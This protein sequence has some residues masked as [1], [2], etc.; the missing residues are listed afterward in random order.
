[1]KRLIVGMGKS[2]QAVARRLDLEGATYDV[3]DDRL[4]LEAVRERLGHVR[5]G[6]FTTVDGIQPEIYGEV[7]VSPGVSIRHPVLARFAGGNAT[8]MGELEFAFR[9]CKGR[10]VAVTGS[11]GKSTTVT[12]IDHILSRCGFPSRLCGN[13]GRPFTDLVD[14]A[15]EA[16]YVLEVSSF[17][18]EHIQTFC[19]QVGVLLNVAPD[20]I[21]RHGSFEA[22]R[23]AKL[24]LF[25]NQRPEHWA[26]FP[27]NFPVKPPGKGRVIEVPGSEARWED[28]VL[29]VGERFRLNRSALPLLGAHNLENTAFACTA[30]HYFGV[31]GGQVEQALRDFKGLPHRLEVLGEWEGRTWINDSKATNVHAT[32]A[33][34]EAMEL[35]YVLILGGCD[36]GDRFNRIRFGDH[37]PKAVVAYGET[38]AM[39]CED[40]AEMNPVKVIDFQAACLKAHQLAGSGAAVLLAPACASFDQFDS[41]TH[42]GD[43][44]RS[45]FRQGVK[46]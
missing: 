18:L 12:M 45:V 10:V 22:Y 40:L 29:Q 1:M 2:G 24:K 9:R 4:D 19:P 14:E 31:S 16:I 37:P 38:A 15:R 23:D 8:V 20:H 34:I 3:F 42:R 44:F 6:S 25:M 27:A 39:I 32:Q 30:A 35:P 26:V 33:A 13:I 28:G 7:V 46:S 43:A 5:F 17:Q 36:K 11:N 41:F 21:D